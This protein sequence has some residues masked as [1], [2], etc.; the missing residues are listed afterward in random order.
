MISRDEVMP[1]LLAS[2]PSFVDVWDWT[3]NLDDGER[4]LYLDVAAFG[5]HVL[6]LISAGKTKELP[7]VFDTVEHLHLRGDHYV[8]ELATIGILECFQSASADARGVDPYRD[9]E[10]WLRPESLR[11]WK[12][13]DQFWEGDHSALRE[14]PQ[15][16]RTAR[17]LLARRRHVRRK[18]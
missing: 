8:R 11:W 12:R 14:S 18:S 13:L 9:V 4:L 15:W 17:R 5:R 6:D 10:P 16:R 1:L 2:C 3:E 7:A